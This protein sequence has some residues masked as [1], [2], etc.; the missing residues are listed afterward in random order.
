MA[1]R[2]APGGGST[3]RLHVWS[4]HTCCIRS[5]S[6]SSSSISLSFHRKRESSSG[7]TLPK[8]LGPP[9]PL[10]CC[11]AVLARSG[12]NPSC[13]SS[14]GQA[15][16]RGR[17]GRGGHHCPSCHRQCRFICYIQPRSSLVPPPLGSF[18][19]PDSWCPHSL[20]Q[21]WAACPHCTGGG[22]K[23]WRVSVTCQGKRWLRQEL[24][25]GQVIGWV[26]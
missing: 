14:P 26:G 22:S 15:G 25:L 8:P 19:E 7:H 2:T 20:W 5:L 12:V 10:R 1:G 9:D 21:R 24:T 17:V 13:L 18:R 4:F 23:T 6:P 16:A 11:S 3:E